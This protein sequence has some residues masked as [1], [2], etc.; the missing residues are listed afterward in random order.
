MKVWVTSTTLMLFRPRLLKS[1]H[2]LLQDIPL[3]RQFMVNCGE[4][5]RW[6]SVQ[7]P[8]KMW[9]IIPCTCELTIHVKAYYMRLC[10]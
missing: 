8:E 10:T 9:V 6:H 3:A 1:E 7:N 5:S 4:K 2:G